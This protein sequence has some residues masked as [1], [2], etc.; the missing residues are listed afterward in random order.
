MASTSCVTVGRLL[1]RA[2]M[3]PRLMSISSARRTLTDIG[4]T[5]SS[6]GPPN[7]STP[8]TVVVKPLGSTTTSSPGRSAPLATWPA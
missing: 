2:S 8:A 1:G 6:I 5:A 3:S 7:T 4:G